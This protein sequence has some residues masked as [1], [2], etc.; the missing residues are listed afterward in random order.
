MLIFIREDD[1]FQR[2]PWNCLK[3]YPHYGVRNRCETKLIFSDFLINKHL[4]LFRDKVISKFGAQISNKMNDSSS[5]KKC[6]LINRRT[7]ERNLNEH[8][9][10][11]EKEITDHTQ[12]SNSGMEFTGVVYLE[13]LPFV[14][15]IEVFTKNDIIIAPHGAGLIHSIW[16]SGK[17]IVEIVFKPEFYPLYRRICNITNNRILQIPYE[18]LSP[19]I[20]LVNQVIENIDCS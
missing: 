4:T 3:Y 7:E 2:S 6:V 15:Q 19:T 9:A 10:W 5:D 17:L 18:K 11:M 16:T 13:D 14:K 1:E 12:K 20:S 8:L